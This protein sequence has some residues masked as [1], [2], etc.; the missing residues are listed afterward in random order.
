M[1]MQCRVEVAYTAKPPVTPAPKL[2]Y[3]MK[4]RHR[5][6]RLAWKNGLC[7]VH[8]RFAGLRHNQWNKR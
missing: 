2:Y 4:R 6:K 8:W 5:C 3:S 7:K 1:T